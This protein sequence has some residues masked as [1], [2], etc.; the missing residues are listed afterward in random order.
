MVSADQIRTA[1]GIIGNAISFILF[2]SPMPTFYRI[3]KNKYVEHFS[4]VPYVAT[5]LNCML[6]VLYGLPFVKPNST[7]IITINGAGTVIELI[8]IFI[9]L[10]YSDGSRRIKALLLL[11][12]DIAFI[13][14]VAAIVLSIFKSH[15]RR[16]LIVGILCIIFCIMM[17]ASPLSIMK[18]VIRTKSTEYMPLYLSIA[19]FFNGL[20]WTTYSL[21]HLDI[22]LTIPNAIG[23]LFA[24]AQLLLHAIY[25]KST[26]Q[27]SNEGKNEVTLSEVNIT[28]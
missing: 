12:T 13:V 4:V 23:L 18:R 7:L 15:E 10:L 5:L 26:K 16:T 22:N 1:V 9:Y 2:L 8:Y 27:Q 25:N 21:I 6:W 17:Y 24:I 20:C 14:I 3:C 11:F 19:Y 28:H